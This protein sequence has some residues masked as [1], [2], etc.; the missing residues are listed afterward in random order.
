VSSMLD[1]IVIFEDK[2]DLAC[3]IWIDHKAC[4]LLNSS[5]KHLNL[6]RMNRELFKH[7]QIRL[8]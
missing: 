7:T 3:Y 1:I 4:C 6:W 5:K 8:N 2:R